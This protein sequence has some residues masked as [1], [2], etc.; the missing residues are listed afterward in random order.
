[1]NVPPVRLPCDR[2]D[3]FAVLSPAGMCGDCQP[4]ADQARTA[5]Q[6]QDARAKA[7]FRAEMTHLTGRLVGRRVDEVTARRL[8]NQLERIGA[9]S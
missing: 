1:M 7:K 2:C 4:A 9:A 3:R 6:L 8:L 5:D